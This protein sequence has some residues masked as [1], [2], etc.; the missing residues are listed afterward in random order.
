MLNSLK[1]YGAAPDS[2]KGRYSPAECVGII[3]LR[4][5]ASPT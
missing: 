3:H 5:T 2:A 1:V 4:S